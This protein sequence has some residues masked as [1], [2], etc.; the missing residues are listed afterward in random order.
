MRGEALPLR[1]PLYSV[2]R[3]YTSPDVFFREPVAPRTPAS[4]A[5]LLSGIPERRI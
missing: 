4:D 3:G 5:P 2:R 1:A